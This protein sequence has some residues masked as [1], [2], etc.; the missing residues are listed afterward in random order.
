MNIVLL[1]SRRTTTLSV[2]LICQALLFVCNCVASM[3]PDVET[4]PHSFGGDP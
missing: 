1:L 3:W 2:I 4:L